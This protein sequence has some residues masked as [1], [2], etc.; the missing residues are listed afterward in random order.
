MHGKRPARRRAARAWASWCLAGWVAACTACYL[1]RMTA[2][3][4][5]RWLP[6]LEATHVAETPLR[7]RP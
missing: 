2:D 5:G 4:L 6:K 1:Y 7:D 3:H